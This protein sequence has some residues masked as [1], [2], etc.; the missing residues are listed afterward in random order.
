MP[1]DEFIADAL[2]ARGDYGTVMPTMNAADP[3]GNSR[4]TVET[5]RLVVD[6]CPDR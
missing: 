6:V 1:L 5:D 4:L 2:D 3:H